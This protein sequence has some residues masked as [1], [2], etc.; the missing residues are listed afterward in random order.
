MLC[1]YP[2]FAEEDQNLL[3]SKI[4]SGSYDMIPEDW[5]F[6]SPSG[7]DLVKRILVVDPNRRITASEV[8]ILF[9]GNFPYSLNSYISFFVRSR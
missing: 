8:R 2:P 7:T 5:K 1:G 3:F 9:S 6:I 4:R